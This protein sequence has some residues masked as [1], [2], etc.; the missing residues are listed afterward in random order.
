MKRISG[1]ALIL[2]VFWLIN[3]GHFTPMLLGFG[4]LSVAGVILINRRMEAV[5]GEYEPPVFLSFR[6][7]AY[8]FWLLCEIIKSNIDVVK[9]IW[10]PVPDIS[11]T[12]FRVNA[13]QKTDLCKVLYANSITMTPGTVTMD[14][15]ENTFEVHALT[16][17]GS[18]GV[19][20][21]E[22]DRRVIRL[23]GRV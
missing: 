6:L 22:M 18:E 14:I 4:V 9:R 5:D 8:L 13:S 10:Q 20:E 1:L 23:E 3:S 12:V 2:S 17:E 11:P 19:Q 16:R 7:P 15:D 21:G